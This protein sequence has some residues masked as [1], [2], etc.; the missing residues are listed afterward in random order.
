MK[1]YKSDHIPE[2]PVSKNPMEYLETGSSHSLDFLTGGGKM[3]ELIRSY[4]W[5][6]TSLGGRPQEWPSSL[7]T[8]LRILLTT[9]H[10]IFIF[11]GPELI[12]F[13]NDAYSRSLGPE[14]HPS[15]LGQAGESAWV[16]IWPII[17]PQIQQVMRGEEATWHENQL[18]PIIRHGELQEVY[19]TYSFGPIDEPAADSGIGGV[20][21]ICTET[22]QQVLA[23]RRMN[24][25]HQRF[26]QLFEQSPTFMAVLRGPQHVFEF[27]NPGYMRLVG[28]RPVIGRT[29]A[30]ALPEAVPQGYLELLDNVYTSGEAFIAKGAKFRSDAVGGSTDESYLDFVYQPIKDITGQINGIF[31]EGVDVTDRVIAETRRAA[32]MKLTDA[33]R[34]LKSHGDITFRA[35]QI[36][37]E[38]LDVGRATYCTIDVIAETA[39][40]ERYWYAPGM[41]VPTG[42]V[43]YRDYGSFIDD[44][45]AGRLI[46]INDVE[47]DSRTS[48]AMAAFKH[49]K[50]G[51]FIN[52][53]VMEN[54]QLV[55]V[56]ALTNSK[57]R[58]WTDSEIAFAQEVAAR[59][60]TVSERLRSE[61]ALQESEAKFR[62]IADAIP[63]MVWS[64]LPDG[65]HDYYNRQWYEYTGVP[66]GSIE[67]HGWKKL[68]HQEDQAR[69]H[70][71]W[72]H[73]LATGTTFEIQYRLRHH[74]GDY[75]WIL[76]RAL[77]IQ[78][79]SGRIIRWMGTSTDI[80][81]QKLAEVALR[82]SS[83]RKDEFLA[84]LAHELRNPLA[85]I[86]TAAYLLEIAKND[87]KQIS[88]ASD[89][90]SRQVS[91]LTTLVDD[92]LDVSRVSRGLVEL[93]NEHVDIKQV[94][95]HAI[96]QAR[97]LIEARKHILNL[98]T[99][100]DHA[101]VMGD[102]TRLVQVV[103]NLLN[104]AAKYTPQGGEIDL[105]VAVQDANVKITIADNG[106]GI[107]PSLLPHI[108]D[109]FTQ[110]ERTPDRTQGGLGLGLALVKSLTAMH[111]GNVNASS[112]GNGAGSTFTVTL[113]LL[114]TPAMQQ[115]DL[116]GD[117][118]IPKAKPLQ[119]MIVD[120]NTDAATSLAFLL[121]LHGHH[122]TVRENSVSALEAAAENTPQLFI[123]DIGLPD[124]DGYEL[125]RRLR[126]NPVTKNAV[127]IALT[128]YGQEHDRVL[129][130][131]AGFDHHFVKPI[132]M[133][134]LQRILSQIN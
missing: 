72:K 127:I 124:M 59:T 75:R 45:K 64:T 13:Y 30:D 129:S 118:K 119:L 93:E 46:I 122:V 24:I 88:R 25:E 131:A 76:G 116:P 130:K 104:N 41:E 126:A 53:P 12:C 71:T 110:G 105:L 26:A 97:P 56:F 100:C 112:L 86:S 42:P 63:Q 35:A 20:L 95:N 67:K 1:K 123:L 77:P 78:D 60:R 94:V 101:F 90:I 48:S 69:T 68:L 117:H 85:P 37:G 11:W 89:I 34:P 38:T 128:G 125:T 108:F 7:R 106:S 87:E 23:E 62:T 134:R 2:K 31:V 54:N 113:P 33:L 49:R 29:V 47:A 10:P 44:M 55:A 19:W 9:Q 32:L 107:A 84:M 66:K 51:A 98:R 27:A 57:P 96:E 132:D 80:H 79:Q 22:T 50:A 18:V 36:L 70:Q 40:I 65:S 91:H 99:E 52:V 73:S 61:I 16:E 15:I 3:G 103:A 39:F 121:E 14:K 102:K 111:G 74:S 109:L 114:E 28:G 8:T 83:L 120:D 133:Q 4:P 21:V 115:G 5:A 43:S 92:L 58:V 81:D 17:G 6:N 82:E